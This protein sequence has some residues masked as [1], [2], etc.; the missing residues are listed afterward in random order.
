MTFIDAFQA[1]VWPRDQRKWKGKGRRR[2]EKR[3]K[4]GKNSDSCQ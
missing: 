4:E 2:R 3:E 1:S